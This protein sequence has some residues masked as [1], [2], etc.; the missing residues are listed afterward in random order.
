MYWLVK[1]TWPSLL[2]LDKLIAIIW[3]QA[4]L[5]TSKEAILFLSAHPNTFKGPNIL[6]LSRTFSL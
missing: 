6:L 2:T 5:V 3:N 1:I 4:I